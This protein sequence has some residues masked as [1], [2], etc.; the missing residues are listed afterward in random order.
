MNLLGRN[1][2]VITKKRFSEMREI[3]IRM[4]RRRYP[5]VY[6]SD[7]YVLPRKIFLGQRAQHD[8]GR[9]TAADSHHKAPPSSH[10]GNGFR[11][12]V[13]CGRAGGRFL[14]GKHFNFHPGLSASEWL[15]GSRFSSRL[16]G[17][18]W[19]LRFSNRI[20]PAS[21]RRYSLR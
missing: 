20:L 15:S 3:P 13:L 21:W 19:S 11:G 17:S 2:R 1:R 5:F 16:V 12:N 8:P 9:T 10:G 14:V 18:N 6:L 7:V 4:P